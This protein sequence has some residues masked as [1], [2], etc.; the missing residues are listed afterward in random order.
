VKEPSSR[1]ALPMAVLDIVVVAAATVFVIPG[2]VVVMF[3]TRS[4]L[5]SRE[6]KHT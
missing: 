6:K 4:L 5:V 2:V 1:L 3:C